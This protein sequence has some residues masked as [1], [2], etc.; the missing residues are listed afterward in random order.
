MLQSSLPAPAPLPPRQ[1]PGPGPVPVPPPVQP[2]PPRRWRVPA[3]LV[4]VAILGGA[5]Y[6]LLRPQQAVQYGTGQ[7]VSTAPAIPAAPGETVI[8][9]SGQTSARN[10]ALIT[11]PMFRGPD[12]RADL[13]LLR[14]AK[15]GSFVK[16]GDVV[17]EFDPQSVIDHLDD[18]RDQVQQ[19]QNEVG[20]KKAQQDIEWEGLQQNLRIAKADMD[21]ALLDLKAAEVKT[22][23][24]RELLKLAADEAQAAYKQLAA[25]VQRKRISQQADLRVTEIDFR[26]QEIHLQ[27]HVQDLERF[28]VTSPIAGLAVMGQVFRGEMRQIQEGDQVFPGQQIM[29]IVDLSSMQVDGWVSQADAS[30]LR[31]GQTA[32]VG[33]DAF[34]G[35][36]FEGKIVSMGALAVKGIW[37]TYFIR[38]VPVQITIH[39]QDPRLIPDLSAW[40]EVRLQTVNAGVK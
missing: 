31:V 5:L 15:P 35:L 2:K 12:S 34:P 37:D 4:V 10:Y 21:R 11:V 9:V 18:T 28:K 16:K 19:A 14:T 24:E 1:V 7:I 8:R 22:E 3:L 36:K 39:G 40:A 23:I 26:K 30:R 27:R 17:C 6:W 38:N 33:L 29:K 13:T 32:V 25:D 20:K